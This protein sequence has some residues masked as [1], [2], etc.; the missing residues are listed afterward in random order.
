MNAHFETSV[1]SPHPFSE[2]KGSQAILTSSSPPPTP[3]LVDATVF[4][5][6]ED[7]NT[8]M[9]K[10]HWENSEVLNY[11]FICTFN[12]PKNEPYLPLPPQLSAKQ[13]LDSMNQEN[14]KD[15]TLSINESK[16][17]L[18]FFIYS[19]FSINVLFTFIFALSIRSRSSGSPG[20]VVFADRMLFENNF[21]R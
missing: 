19:Y 6:K 9:L 13:Y 12:V 14:F 4:K 1:L 18:N 8:V 7:D 21:K 16:N 15:L 10:W 2:Q 11:G 17:L 3:L 20:G 5:G